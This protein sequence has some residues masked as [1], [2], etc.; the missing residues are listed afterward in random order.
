LHR[1][2]A[3]RQNT[4]SIFSDRITRPRSMNLRHDSIRRIAAFVV[5]VVVPVVV[6]RAPSWVGDE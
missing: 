4:G 1:T 6:T 3:L 2:P 5:V